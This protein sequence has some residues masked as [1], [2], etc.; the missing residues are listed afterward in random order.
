MVAR[1]ARRHDTN[2]ASP[3][4][5]NSLF[6]SDDAHVERPQTRSRA[7][8]RRRELNDTPNDRSGYHVVDVHGTLAHA[9]VLFV[10]LMVPENRAGDAGEPGNPSHSPRDASNC[11]CVRVQRQRHASELAHAESMPSC[12]T[13]FA[14]MIKRAPS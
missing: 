3:L 4:R 5:L 10:M 2:F 13:S 14:S 6:S 7:W 1:L 8:S 12:P 11:C 9:T